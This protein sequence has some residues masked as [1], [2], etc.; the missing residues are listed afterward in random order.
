VFNSEVDMEHPD[1]K[2]GMIFSNVKELR[3][4]IKAYMLRKEW[5]LRK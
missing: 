3:A 4:S 5:K 1:C 2:V